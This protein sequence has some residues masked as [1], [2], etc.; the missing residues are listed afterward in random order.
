M[1][2]AIAGV[3]P[4][5]EKEVTVMAVWPSIAATAYG[6]WWGRRFANDIGITLFGVPIT[7]GR[8]LALVSIPAILPVYFHMVI[9]KLPFIVFGIYNSLVPLLSV[10]E[11]PRIGRTGLRWRRTAERFIRPVRFGRSRGRTGASMVLCGRFG[12]S[13]GSG[14]DVPPAGSSAPRVIQANLRED[15]YGLRRCAACA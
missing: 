6:R 2:Q 4:D 5:T 1:A 12:F 14:R 13:Q 9:P 3:V 10:D 7:V 8:L 15:S 11:S